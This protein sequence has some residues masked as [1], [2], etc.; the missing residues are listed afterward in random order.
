MRREIILKRLRP[1]RS[2]PIKNL[3]IATSSPTNPFDDLAMALTEQSRSFQGGGLPAT[4]GICAWGFVSVSSDESHEGYL[5]K[6]T[7][8]PKSPIVGRRPSVPVGWCECHTQCSG[9]LRAPTPSGAKGSQEGLC[10]TRLVVT[11]L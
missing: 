7:P 6:Y 1:K 10:A 4:G 8:P 2:N 5:S 11:R 9:T 3:F